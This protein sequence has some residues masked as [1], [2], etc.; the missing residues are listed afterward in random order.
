MR[1]EYFVDNLSDETITQMIDNALR[2][3]KNRKNNRLKSSWLKII[4]AVA[5]IALVIGLINLLPVFNG[6]DVGAEIEENYGENLGLLIPDT[7][8]E[9]TFDILDLNVK[10]F[11]PSDE[12]YEKCTPEIYDFVHYISQVADNVEYEFFTVETFEAM[13]NM[14]KSAPVYIQEQIPRLE[15]ILEELKAGKQLISRITFDILD[16]NGNSVMEVLDNGKK[17]LS[18]FGPEN[19]ELYSPVSYAAMSHKSVTKA[20]HDLTAYYDWDIQYYKN[21]GWNININYYTSEEYAKYIKEYKK[22]I[23]NKVSQGY[24]RKLIEKIV[25][26]M[27]KEVE[28]IKQGKQ[29]I[30]NVFMSREIDGK[31]TT[32]KLMPTGGYVIVSE[33]DVLNDIK[34]EKN[35][36]DFQTETEEE[37]DAAVVI[38]DQGY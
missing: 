38:D 23:E 29:I 7:T 36:A 6:V 22:D 18:V 31:Y 20:Y 26:A 8:E 30:S 24:P 13:I 25:A 1:D 27:E 35:A 15:E 11:Y 37:I 19:Y 5:A 12:L 4:P 14:I 3:E 17:Y 34:D 9:T 21:L 16:E 33:V 32:I 28:L 10:T 2:F